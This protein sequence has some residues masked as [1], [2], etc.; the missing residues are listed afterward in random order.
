M[1]LSLFISFSGLYNLQ[2]FGEKQYYFS[3][4]SHKSSG[5]YKWDQGYQTSVI[6]SNSV[7]GVEDID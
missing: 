7:G 4:F 6:N 2:L 5:V 3:L 1:S